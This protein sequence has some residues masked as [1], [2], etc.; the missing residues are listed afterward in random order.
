MILG[1]Y[2]ILQNPLFFFFLV[3]QNRPSGKINRDMQVSHTGR[4]L[5][6]QRY[7]L[8]SNPQSELNV[9][10]GIWKYMPITVACVSTVAW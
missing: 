9:E 6:F 10:R 5:F 8:S 1:T 7:W 3:H 2:V 4:Q